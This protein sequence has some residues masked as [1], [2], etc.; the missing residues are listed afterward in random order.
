MSTHMHNLTC[1]AGQDNSIRTSQN[2]LPTVE[3]LERLSHLF[4]YEMF[5]LLANTVDYRHTRVVLGAGVNVLKIKD[6]PTN[7]ESLNGYFDRVN[8]KAASGHI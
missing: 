8:I 4:A 2:M 1:K 3:F 6:T 7:S 5:L